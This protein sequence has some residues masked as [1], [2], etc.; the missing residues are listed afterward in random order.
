MEKIIQQT[1]VR[2]QQPTVY[3]RSTTLDSKKSLV[4]QPGLGRQRRLVSLCHVGQRLREER[5]KADVDS[6]GYELSCKE[7]PVSLG[8]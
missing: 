5:R 7:L 1:K 3:V 6:R 2:L 8:R 4:Q